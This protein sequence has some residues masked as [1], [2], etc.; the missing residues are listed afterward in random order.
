MANPIDAA[1]AAVEEPKRVRTATLTVTLPSGRIVGLMVPVDLTAQEG[2]HLVG[3]IGTKMGAE[4]AKG[5]APRPR[6]IVPTPALR[7]R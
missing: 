3:F 1:F 7:R 5:Q 6:L 2:L 4:L